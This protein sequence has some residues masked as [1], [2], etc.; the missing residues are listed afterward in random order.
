[1]SD[2]RVSSV[3]VQDCGEP[4]VDTRGVV[5]AS[6]YLDGEGG[7][8]SAWVRSN[9]R[10]QLVHAAALLAP[11]HTLAL[12][13]GWR[14][15]TVQAQAFDRQVQQ[16]AGVYPNAPLERLR[17]LA[18]RFVSPPEVAPH[19]TGAAVDVLL[20]RP[21]GTEVDMG[22]PINTNP[23]DS[24]GFCYADHPDVPQAARNVRAV[25]GEAMRRAGF[26]NYPTE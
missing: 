20:L 23:Q 15:L 14:P 22:C 16:L 18:S 7:A 10:D 6:A 13:E 19:P 4:L 26:V 8:S 17:Q 11:A 5:T 25:L 2:P 1:M 9:V 24:A 12:E 3:L 21:D